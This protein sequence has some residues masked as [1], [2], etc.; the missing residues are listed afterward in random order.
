MCPVCPNT[1]VFM[2]LNIVKIEVCYALT[3]CCNYYNITVQYFSCEIH[4]VNNI[5]YVLIFTTLKF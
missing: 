3:K 1:I 5:N 2:N 4:F